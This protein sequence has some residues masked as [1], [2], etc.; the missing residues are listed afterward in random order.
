MERWLTYLE[1]D[2]TVVEITHWEGLQIDLRYADSLYCGQQRAFL[3]RDAASKLKTALAIIAQEHPGYRIVIWDA[4]RP[5]FAQMALWQQVRGTE[6]VAFVSNPRKGS[7]HNFGMAMDVSAQT[8]QGKLVD[9]GSNFDEYSVLATARRRTEDSLVQVGQLTERQVKNRRILRD[10]LQRAG[11]I[12]LPDEWWHFN[13]GG[14]D[15][16]RASYRIL[17][18]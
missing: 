6:R 11:F 14:S 4:A 3:Q 15:A 7:L 13:A 1:R 17:D 10:I 5:V 12:Q 18:P 2:S 9:M 8:A 16:V